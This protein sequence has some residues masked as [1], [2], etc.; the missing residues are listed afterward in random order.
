MSRI[1]EV[2][3]PEIHRIAREANGE[4]VPRRA[5]VDR[6]VERLRVQLEVAWE[7]TTQHGAFDSL[8]AYAGNLFDHLTGPQ[9]RRSGGGLRKERVD[10]QWAVASDEKPPEPITEEVRARIAARRAARRRDR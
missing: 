1:T 2:V 4:L 6:L 7:T 9:W 10:G 5:V 3:F 8:E